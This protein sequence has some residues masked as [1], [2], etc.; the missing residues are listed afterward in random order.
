MILASNYQHNKIEGKN[1]EKSRGRKPK[2]NHTEYE[3]K[4]VEL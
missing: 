4:H 1:I 3:T 2:K